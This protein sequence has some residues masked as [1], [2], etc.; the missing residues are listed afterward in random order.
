MS[1]RAAACTF[2]SGK[3]SSR[4]SPPRARAP[5]RG[6]EDRRDGA[7]QL[8]E[9]GVEVRERGA[10][11]VEADEHV[12]RMRAPAG[13]VGI[14]ARHGDDFGKRGRETREIVIRPCL[15]PDLGADGARLRAALD[16]LGRDAKVQRD[17]LLDPRTA[18]RQGSSSGEAST[19]RRAPSRARR[20]SSDISMSRARRERV[21][22]WPA[23]VLAL[24]LGS[25]VRLS[26]TSTEAAQSTS[27]I[28]P[29]AALRRERLMVISDREGLDRE[30]LDRE[31]LDRE[32][33]DREELAG[34]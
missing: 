2:A 13:R 19:S 28:L 14:I 20:V 24:P 1:I 8:G 11:L 16:E 31:G 29:T 10:G 25:M 17:R 15:D 32:G 34:G 4:K 30:G 26:H 9:E 5:E 27:L 12:V 7:L 23:L 18:R 3:L 33:L 22:S 21:A 6:I